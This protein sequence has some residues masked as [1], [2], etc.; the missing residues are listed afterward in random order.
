MNHPAHVYELPRAKKAATVAK[1]ICKRG[2]EENSSRTENLKH[3]AMLCLAYAAGLHVSEVVNVE[4]KDIDSK[5]M[6]ITLRQA[7]GKK[8]RQVMLRE[9]LLVLLRNYFRKYKPRRWLFE[10][11]GG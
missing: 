5:R 2:S 4:L 8:D 10:G 9:K 1:R 11:Q 6:M 3:H 7:K